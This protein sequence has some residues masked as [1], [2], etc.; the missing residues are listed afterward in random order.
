MYCKHCGKEIAEDSKFCQHCGKQIIE[1]GESLKNSKA[2]ISNSFLVLW[3]SVNKKFLLLYT[4]WF[5]L[6]LLCLCLREPIK[7]SPK[8]YFFPFTENKFSYM[9]DVDYYDITEFIAYTIL[10]PLVVFYVVKYWYKPRK[11]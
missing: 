6:N 11:R 1:D 5:V 4:I 10:I 8:N 7:Y 3:S 9:F 2:K